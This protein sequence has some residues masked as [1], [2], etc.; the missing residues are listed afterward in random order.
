MKNAKL[1]QSRRYDHENASQLDNY[2]HYNVSSFYPSYNM[3]SYDI[4]NLRNFYKDLIENANGFNA[5]ALVIRDNKG[6]YVLYS[7]ET[8]VCSYIDGT[9]TKLWSGYSNTSLKH[10]NIFRKFVGLEPL[11]K[12]DWIMMFAYNEQ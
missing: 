4:K 7:Y 11:S 2:M 9:F 10:V 5:R 12:Y 3:T 1:Y 6:N 8:P